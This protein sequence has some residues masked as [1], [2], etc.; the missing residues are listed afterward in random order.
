[1]KPKNNPSFESDDPL[2][3]RMYREAIAERPAFSTELHHRILK[4]VREERLDI[5]S[6]PRFEPQRRLKIAAA[7]AIL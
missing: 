4:S 5:R 7:A 1:M 3:D 2:V 6:H